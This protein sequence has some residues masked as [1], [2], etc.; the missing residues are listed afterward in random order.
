MYCITWSV[1]GE[2]GIK[3]LDTIHLRP[4]PRPFPIELGGTY[5]YVVVTFTLDAT[6]FSFF[7]DFISHLP[8]K[9]RQCVNKKMIKHSK[10]H[11]LGTK[12]K[13]YKNNVLIK[14]MFQNV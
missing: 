2:N 4:L 9:Q 13:H 12:I 11:M 5:A 7:D 8:K 1:D 6:W 14:I 10:N 3:V